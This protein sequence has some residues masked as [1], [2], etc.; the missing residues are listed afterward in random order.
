MAEAGMFPGVI[1][2]LA[3]WYRT[4][5]FSRPMVWFFAISNLAGI[6]GSLLCYGISYMNGLQG[7]S[8]WRWVFIFEGLLTI[9]LSGFI[10][11]ILPDLPK[12]PRSKSW[13]TEREQ[14]FIEARLPLN[15]PAT[16]EKN[17]DWREAWHAFRSPT[18]YG[19]M[20]CQTFMNLALSAFNWYLPTIITD[21][22]FVGLPRNQLLNIPPVGVGILGILFSSWFQSRAYVV[23]PAYIK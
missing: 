12:S 22:G 7:L 18:V 23:R 5:E 15:A 6:V 20:L 8:A 16:G 4:D 13:L 3:Y 9:I 19:F 11:W 2:H 17:F 14:E 21:F 10:F 1:T